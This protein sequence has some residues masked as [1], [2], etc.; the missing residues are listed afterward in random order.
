MKPFDLYPGDGKSFLP[1]RSGSNSR[2]GYGL[3]LQRLTNQ[4]RCAYCNVD[5]VSDYYRWLLINVD[6]V[7]PESECRRL[8]IPMEWAQSFSN[9]V[10]SCAGC[11][12]FDNRYPIRDVESKTDWLPREFF[13]LRN[14]IFRD[15]SEKIRSRRDEEQA[16]FSSEPW[17]KD[18][19]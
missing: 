11:N 2:H 6:H 14:K 13:E 15:R 5:L 4:H 10:I 7:I 1:K 3:Q 12:L 8:G 9:Q 18:H 19:L 17:N 16:F